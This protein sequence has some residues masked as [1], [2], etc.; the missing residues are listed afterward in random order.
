MRATVRLY[1]RPAAL[2]LL[3]LVAGGTGE[4]R[5]QNCTGGTLLSPSEVAALLTDRYACGGAGGQTWNELHS[6]GNIIDYKLGPNDPKDP[7]TTVGGYTIASTTVGDTPVG[8]VTYN[9]NNG[10]G[11]FAYQIRSAGSPAT[12]TPGTYS[13]CGV[14]GAANFS[15]TVST[16]PCSAP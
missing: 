11:S 13:F 4:A 15:I 16:A 5:A 8:R 14:A 2:A 9:Y 6:A 1:V 3:A 7:S 12:T 10:G